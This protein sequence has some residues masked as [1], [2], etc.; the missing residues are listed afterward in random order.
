MPDL[1]SPW[2]KSSRSVNDGAC[3]EV[4][5]L[6]GIRNADDRDAKVCVRDSQ[7]KNPSFLE[8]DLGAWDLFIEKIARGTLVLQRP[9]APDQ[10]S[11]G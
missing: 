3:V 5:I 7:G 1:L 8:F 11:A 10:A 4:S 2:R 9:S 6:A